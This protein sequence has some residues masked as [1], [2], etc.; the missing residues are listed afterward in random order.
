MFGMTIALMLSCV[1]LLGQMSQQER[2]FLGP[3]VIKITEAMPLLE[4][5]FKASQESLTYAREQCKATYD[6]I[7]QTDSYFQ[8]AK[9]KI[10]LVYYEHEVDKFQK[11]CQ[12]KNIQLIIYRSVLF[13]FGDAKITKSQLKMDKLYISEVEARLSWA[14]A[15]QEQ[16]KQRLAEAERRI[17]EL[18]EEQA[19]E[20]EHIKTLE[21][22]LEVLE[23]KKSWSNFQERMTLH[24]QIAF[25]KATVLKLQAEAALQAKNKE[26]AVAEIQAMMF[27]ITEANIAI[28]VLRAVY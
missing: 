10:Q 26:D 13:A 7:L 2:D 27:E 3:Q 28:R 17:S 19:A 23:Y 16:A 15:Q 1:G 11:E 21:K 22:R 20:E 18:P 24:S 6:Q 25:G 5:D 12:E 8:K 4:S 9:L 14:Q